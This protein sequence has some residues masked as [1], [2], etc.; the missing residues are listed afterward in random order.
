MLV[1]YLYI[2]KHK[3]TDRLPQCSESLTLTLSVTLH[4]ILF[5]TQ[6]HAEL[7]LLTCHLE[8][9]HGIEF[10]HLIPGNDWQSTTFCSQSMRD[11]R[12]VDY[13]CATHAV[14]GIDNKQLGDEILCG[15]RDLV[16]VRGWEI[17]LACLDGL[18]QHC[19]IFVVEWW[20]ATQENVRDDTERPRVNLF[21]IRCGLE[22]F[23]CNI[24]GS[25]TCSLHDS[26]IIQ[27]LRETEVG[28]LH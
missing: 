23:R 15:L 6:Q 22:N 12:I 11:P 14:S 3:S 20:K 2:Y 28:N 17:V 13:V 7:N 21:I 24:S 10:F 18:E 9:A 27:Q 8:L 25:P 19:V 16:P 1:I 4:L 26:F 5:L